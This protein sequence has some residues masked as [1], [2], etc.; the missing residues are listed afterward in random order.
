M[1]RTL[2][3]V[4]STKTVYLG[5]GLLLGLVIG[6][7]ALSTVRAAVPD[8]DKVIHACYSTG[9]TS[10]FRITEDGDCTEDETGLNWN[11]GGS[12]SGVLRSNIAGKDLTGAQMVYWDLRN[13]N[14]TGTNLTD[15][16]LLGA[17]LRGSNLTNT[18]FT[19]A[20]LKSTDLRNQT[21]SGN[22]F[23]G[24][25]FTNALL[26]GVTF[27]N[28][29]MRNAIMNGQNLSNVDLSAISSF[30]SMSFNDANLSGAT[31]V[32]SPNFSNTSMSNTNLSNLNLTNADLV[33]SYL[34]NAN[35]SGTDLT[36]VTWYDP[37][38]GSATCPDGS[39]AGQNEDY[40]CIG[41]L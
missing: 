11:Q 15:S 41:H 24:A 22:S 34:L 14:F 35:L 20:N 3:V 26:S 18:T 28:V 10:T 9:V 25:D 8:T 23:F 1:L 30:E 29:D 27:S 38:K 4:R 13:V 21:L 16:S 5:T 36:G 2:S 37:S 40:T 19:G 6:G 31:L 39:S 32:S 12:A 7:Y 33:G 17:D